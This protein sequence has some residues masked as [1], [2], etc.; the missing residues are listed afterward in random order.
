[1]AQPPQHE[2]VKVWSDSD[3][4]ATS[5]PHVSSEDSDG[6]LPVPNPD[7]YGVVQAV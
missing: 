6:V 1:M 3:S 7:W 4:P 2:I 5:G